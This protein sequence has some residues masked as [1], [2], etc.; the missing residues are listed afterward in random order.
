MSTVELRDIDIGTG[1]WLAGS[2]ANEYLLRAIRARGHDHLRISHGYLFQHLI[3]GEPTVT[4]LAAALGVTQQA[5]SK[6]VAELDDLGYVERVVDA[7]DGRARRVRLTRRGRD[8]VQAVR[9]E[10]RALDVAMEEIVGPE[11]LADAR[12]VLA[13]LLDRVGG[14]DAVAQRRVKP[15]T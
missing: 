6:L 11:R 14:A 5:A 4:D 1:A 12:D 2:A 3:E 15:S 8:A 13:T 10:R 7:G 9:D